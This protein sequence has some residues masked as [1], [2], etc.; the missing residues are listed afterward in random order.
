MNDKTRNE[1]ANYGLEILKKC[2]LLVLHE[3]RKSESSLP[4]QFQP[5][6]RDIRK[7]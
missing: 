6:I 7:T 1:F 3:Y 2:V 4:L 5:A